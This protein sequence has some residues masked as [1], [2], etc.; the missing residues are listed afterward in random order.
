MTT[1]ILTNVELYYDLI[2][3]FYFTAISISFS[4]VV[5]CSMSTRFCPSEPQHCQISSTR[6]ESGVLTRFQRGGSVSMAA[7]A[8]YMDHYILILSS[9]YI[10]ITGPIPTVDKVSLCLFFILRSTLHLYPVLFIDEY[11]LVLSIPV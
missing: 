2:F 10:H 5:V 9:D 1:L 11:T 6:G 7:Q 4:V 3:L 8:Y